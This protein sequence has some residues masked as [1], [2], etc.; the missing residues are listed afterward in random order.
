MSNIFKEVVKKGLVFSTCRGLVTPQEL[1][2]LPLIHKSDFSLDGVSK[3]LLGKIRETEVE[4]LISKPS[5]AN[6]DDQLRLAVL[7]EIIADKQEEIARKEAAVANAAHNS[8]IDDLI[9]RKAEEEL[10]SKTVEELQ[11]MKK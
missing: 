4:S 2:K 8:K 6:A 1:Y 10:A 7:K 9:A 5:D 3:L 11:A